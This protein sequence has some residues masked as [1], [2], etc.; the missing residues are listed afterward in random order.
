MSVRRLSLSPRSLSKPLRACCTQVCL[1]NDSLQQ[2]EVRLFDW[3]FDES[4]ALHKDLASLSELADDLVPLR[5][6][7]SFPDD[8]PFSPPLVFVSSPPLASEYVFDGALCMEMLVEWQPTYGNVEALLVQICA[9]LAYSKTRVASLAASAGP[10][11]AGGG[12][13]GAAEGGGQAP[14]QPPLPVGGLGAS[15]EDDE[16]RRE[17]AQRAY[18]NLKTFHAKKGWGSAQPQA[19][20]S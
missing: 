14:G 13:G 8:F 1:L 15:A 12:N 19:H 17:K 20:L 16:A 3:A 5:L 7:I 9:F 6:R 4:S 10:A 2:W 11:T 18:A